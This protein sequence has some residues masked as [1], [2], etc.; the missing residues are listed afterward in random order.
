[1]I[2]VDTSIWIDHLRAADT[3]LMDQL[4]ECR[5]VVHPFVV[6]EIALGGIANRRTIIG[7]LSGLPSCKIASDQEVLAMIDGQGLVASGI[8]Y[9]D[10]HLLASVLLSPGTTLWTRD[11]RLKVVAEGLGVSKG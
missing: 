1:M 10:A 8:G 5:V 11:R 2:L 6:G 4:R 9:L 7:N 3:E